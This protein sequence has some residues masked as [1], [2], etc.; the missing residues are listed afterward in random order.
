M[1]RYDHAR[2]IPDL[3]SKVV[4]VTGANAGIGYHT[5]SELGKHGAKVYLACRTESKARSAIARIESD[6]P[7]LKGLEHLVWLP[8]DLSSIRSAKEAAE[9][10]LGSAKRLDILINN[11]GRLVDTYVLTEEGIE[12]SVAVNHVGHF[13]FTTA[14][15]PLLKETARLPGADIRVVYVSSES[16]H[17]ANLEKEMALFCKMARYGTTKLMNILFTL[18]LHPG[19]VTTDTVGRADLTPLLPYSTQGSFMSLFAATSAQI[20][21]QRETFKGQFLMPFGTIQPLKTKEARDPALAQ[22]LWK[23][24]ETVVQDV[25]ARQS[26]SPLEQTAS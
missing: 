13:V 25:L 4:I 8:L 23:T 12:L 26:T 1:P 11:A 20:V 2:D 7:S 22:T 18:A 14:L 9:A 24:T 3:S 6:A 19:N 5:A 17:M 16:Y 21:T 10:F 15:L